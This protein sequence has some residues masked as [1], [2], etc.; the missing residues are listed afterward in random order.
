MDDHGHQ[1]QR[2]QLIFRENV[3]LFH[4]ENNWVYTFHTGTVTIQYYQ[5]KH[6]AE[7]TGGEQYECS[8]SVVTQIICS[9]FCSPETKCQ[10]GA[11]EITLQLK[12]HKNKKRKKPAGRDV[13]ATCSDH[14]MAFKLIENSLVP[15]SCYWEGVVDVA[16]HAAWKREEF[17]DK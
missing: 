9:D 10:S 17:I 4:T 13:Q 5:T 1:L 16:N 14:L 6:W 3:N 2:G 12:T 7:N 15:Y 8:H 11:S